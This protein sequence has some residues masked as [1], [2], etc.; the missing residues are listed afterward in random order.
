M[1]PMLSLMIVVPLT[2]IVFGPFGVYIGN[3]LASAISFAM[4][5]SAIL[6]TF[7]FGAV[8]IP[9]VIMGLHWALVPVMISNL[10][11]I[12]Y[13]HLLGPVQATAFVGA[14]I[15]LGVFLKTKD[16][17]I[18]STSLSSFIPAFYRGLRSRLF[19][20]C[21]SALSVCLLSPSL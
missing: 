5:K 18:R 10:A 4:G 13:D 12:G 14:G 7:V 17:N 11:T 16:K 8:S 1:I 6:T 19:M 15:A 9:V 20:V 2:V 3:A 21:F